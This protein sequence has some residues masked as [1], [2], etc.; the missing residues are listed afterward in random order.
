MSQFMKKTFRSSIISSLSLAFVGLMLVIASKQIIITISYII[1]AILISFGVMGMINF[2]RKLNND[3]KNA[4]DLIYGI[5]TI[6]LGVLV[7]KNPTAIASIIPFVFGIFI[8]ITSSIKL[9]YAFS[10]KDTGSNLWKSTIVFSILNTIFGLLLIFNPFQGAQVLTQIIGIIIISYSILD[11][12]SSFIIRK[13]V[14]KI[15]E[16][17]KGE[18]PK[19]AVK[20]IS[21]A[22]VV[23]EKTTKN[24]K[25]D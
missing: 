15:H 21:E 4:F 22:K 24:K 16:A 11:I 5:F 2:I 9:L 13:N 14:I 3:D 17:I 10:V 1:G 12:I 6:I 25:G 18:M 7:I 23:S 19:K 20:I 8:I